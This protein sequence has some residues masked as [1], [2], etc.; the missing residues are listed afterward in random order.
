MCGFRCGD[1]SALAADNAHVFLVGTVVLSPRAVGAQVQLLLVTTAA[2]VIQPY[3]AFA[4]F[5]FLHLRSSTVKLIAGK[6]NTLKERA[7]DQRNE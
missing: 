1:R 4:G 7:N 6:Q 3:H 2:H 5:K